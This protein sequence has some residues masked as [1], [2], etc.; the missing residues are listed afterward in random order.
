MCFGKIVILTMIPIYR[1]LLGR[2]VDAPR[3][4]DNKTKYTLDLA[5]VDR[6]LSYGKWSIP[7]Y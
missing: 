6:G 4:A 7:D 5:G 3:V 2:T 1:C